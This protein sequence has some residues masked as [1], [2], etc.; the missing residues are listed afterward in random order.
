M[1][2]NKIVSLKQVLQRN[3]KYGKCQIEISF[4]NKIDK[5]CTSAFFKKIVKAVEV[6]FKYSQP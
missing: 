2:K 4:Q 1:F 3:P 5:F 6:I